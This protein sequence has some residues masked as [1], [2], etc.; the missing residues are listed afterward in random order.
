MPGF[1]AGPRWCGKRLLC[2]IIQRRTGSEVLLAMQKVEGSNPSAASWEGLYLQAFCVRVVSWC[3]C[4]AGLSLG[5]RRPARSTNRHKAALAGRLWELKP[6][7]FCGASHIM[8]RRRSS[9]CSRHGRR[10]PRDSI[11][12]G[13]CAPPAT[14]F[15]HEQSRQEPGRHVRLWSNLGASA[16]PARNALVPITGVPRAITALR[17]IP[18]SWD[19]C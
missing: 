6:V 3:V 19:G 18:E 11:W 4:V 14:A 10:H 8:G 17:K 9:P 2:R 16:V 1:A 15:A 13:R 5:R 7:T 12:R